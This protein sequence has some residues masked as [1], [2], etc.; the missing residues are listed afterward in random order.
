MLS[1]MISD[2]LSDFSSTRKDTAALYESLTP[3]DC[4][5]Q[6]MTEASPVKWH[7][8]HTNWFFE[9]F[10]LKKL[11]P[12]YKEFNSHF[13]SLFNS[14]YQ[15]IG[16]PYSR[17]DRGLLSRPSLNEVISYRA[18]VEDCLCSK[19]ASPSFYD[20]AK[21]LVELGIQ[22]EKQHQELILMDIKH[23][24]F[25]NPMFP[26][27]QK[28]SPVIQDK[29][30]VF[31]HWSEY[32]GGKIAVGASES[33]FAYDNEKP[34]HEVLLRPYRLANRLV[35]N[36]EFLEF[37]ESG[38]Y[39]KS[40]FWLSDGWDFICSNQVKAPLYWQRIKGEW[41]QFTLHGLNPVALQE[42]VSH[43][44]YYEAAAYAAWRGKRLPT[45]I[46]WE[47]ASQNSQG[48]PNY[49][50]IRY[51]IPKPAATSHLTQMMG[52][53]WEWTAS[54]Y[55]PYPGFRPF[56]GDAQEYNG[57]FMNGQYVLRGGACVTPRGHMRRTYRNFFYPHQ[58]WQFS[59]IRLAEDM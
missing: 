55:M 32:E 31:L 15:V 30:M 1:N 51:L 48:E 44:S 47:H 8:A 14:Y 43:I 20:A 3:E 4:Q 24:F 21:E 49:L 36:A 54:A 19:L 33:C 50:D 58:R 23:G 28:N 38:G 26:A 7:L 6:S 37:I 13:S 2:L 45:E 41:M 40:R 12:Q 46:E 16:K 25:Q 18:Y 35:T 9:T 22:H 11:D 34:R 10:I 59:G 39:S 17:P 29:E 27:F 52:D 42:P 56:S 57:K 5:I 53:L